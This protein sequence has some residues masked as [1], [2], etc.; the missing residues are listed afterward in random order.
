MAATGLRGL[1]L[2]CCS[3]PPPARG[4]GLEDGPT[5][6]WTC[7]RVGSSSS[8]LERPNVEARA[9]VTGPGKAL[10]VGQVAEEPA[11]RSQ[12]HRPRPQPEQ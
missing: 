1:G 2:C 8:F 10:L 12:P 6:P 4:W 9:A 5:A 3:P 7:R 11:G